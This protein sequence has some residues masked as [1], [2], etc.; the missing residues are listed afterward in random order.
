MSWVKLTDPAG[1]AVQLC[2]EQM[3]RVRASN[4][5]VDPKAKAIVDL[6]NS[7]MQAVLETVE[8]VIKALPG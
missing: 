8:Q 7:Q 1:N 3:V 6:T 4:G 5:E 2:V